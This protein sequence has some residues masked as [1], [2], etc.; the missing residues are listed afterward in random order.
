MSLGAASFWYPYL[1]QMP[2]VEF[3]CLWAPLELA[4]TQ[5]SSIVEELKEYREEL[6]YEWELFKGVLE[7]YKGVFPPRLIDQGLFL[8]V[9]G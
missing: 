6:Q 9:Y 3:T 8:N 1:R 5:D 4:Q 7:L 2:I